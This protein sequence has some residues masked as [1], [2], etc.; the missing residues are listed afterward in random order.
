MLRRF[1]RFVH[2]RGARSPTLA[3]AV[4]TVAD[5]GNRLNSTLIGHGSGC[6]EQF[7]QCLD[8]PS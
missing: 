7:L 3:Q 8:Y 1:F 6:L 5:Y 4:P 2:L